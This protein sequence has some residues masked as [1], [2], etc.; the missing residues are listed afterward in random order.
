MEASQP[1]CS[2]RM[3]L[4]MSWELLGRV[5]PSGISVGRTAVVKT[6]ETT[7]L[8]FELESILMYSIMKLIEGRRKVRK[9][10]SC[11]YKRPWPVIKNQQLARRH[12][13]PLV[14]VFMGRITQRTRLLFNVTPTRLSYSHAHDNP[15]QDLRS[16]PP[17]YT[18][19]AVKVTRHERRLWHHP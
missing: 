6:K 11:Q 8:I 10:R 5:R 17:W 1:R 4:Q 12:T 14:L 2:P 15:P 19:S 16:F 7:H 3:M 18:E 9:R 13:H